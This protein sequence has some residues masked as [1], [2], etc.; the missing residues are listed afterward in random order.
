MSKEAQ[1]AR[2]RRVMAEELTTNQR[3]VMV[4]YYFQNMAM[5]DIARQRGVHR[6]TI[7]RTLHRAEERVR[8]CLRY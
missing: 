2:V 3:E 8:R 7:C 5:A 4:A 1:L 6:S